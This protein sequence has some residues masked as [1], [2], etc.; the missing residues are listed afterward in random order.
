MPDLWGLTFIVIIIAILI[1]DVP[2]S[3]IVA[4]LILLCQYR[5][6]GMYNPNRSRMRTGLSRDTRFDADES[7]GNSHQ[8]EL[9]PKSTEL[10]GERRN[11]SMDNATRRGAWKNFQRLQQNA[12]PEIGRAHV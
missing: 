1:D 11:R 7:F 8:F 5:Q 12:A 6:E 4:C 3:I 10:S 9:M 2:T